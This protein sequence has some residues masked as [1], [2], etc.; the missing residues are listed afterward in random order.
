LFGALGVAQTA[1]KPEAADR[2]AFTYIGYNLQVTVDPAQ[3]S[4]SC[5]G[6]VTLRNDS[7]VAQPK[8]ALQL[9]SSLKWASVRTASGQRLPFLTNRI[10][11]DVDHTGAVNEAT[12][13]LPEAVR[14]GVTVIL[15]VGYSG[16][17]TLNTT[18]LDRAGM[19]AQV[20]RANDW[21]RISPDF[22]GVRGVGNVAW[23]PVTVE[24]ALLGE[25]KRM[26]EQLEAFKARSAEASVRIEFTVVPVPDTPT[27]TLIGNGK[28]TRG[29][30]SSTLE[31]ARLGLEAP[32]FLIGAY[33]SVDVPNG[34]VWHLPD[35]LAAAQRYATVLGS[36]KPFVS[37]GVMQPVELV[38]I[39]DGAAN[40]ESGPMFLLPL[41]D[42]SE[43]QIAQ[44]LI[45]TATHAAF[46]SPRPW[47]YEGLAHYSQAR[48]VEQQFGRT[49][50]LQFLEQRRAALALA[51]P[52]NPQGPGLVQAE[53]EILYRTKAMFVWWMLRDML[54][55]EVLHR[56]LA[57]Y[58]ADRDKEPSYIQRL[59]EA[60]SKRNL[61]SFFDDW[62]YRDRG[63]P[64]FHIVNVYPRQQLRG[65]YLTTVTVEN[66][67]N[68][69]AEVEVK[70]R[71]KDTGNT[72]RL[73]VPAKQ[74]ASIRLELPL[75]P[76][77]ATVNDGSVPET[78]VSNNTYEIPK[79]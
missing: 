7:K 14:P 5:R 17:I 55:E 15:D 43:N 1:K 11:S 59:L 70:I 48:M 41:T 78:D 35:K 49:G 3:H 30:S 66:S 71:A 31:F 34:R 47:I 72:G 76:T 29:T 36:V 46:Y 51:E 58:R 8:V 67:G 61:E 74:K 60:E 32:L 23:Y 9:S 19:S 21:D 68:A 57:K 44:L 26:L 28:F 62:V 37:T 16:T 69:G 24:P 65:G 2:S 52:E 73:Y 27:A 64:E 25:G 12:V 45:H 18:R 63:L 33:A 50:A 13:E 54:G 22:T 4:L 39:P 75:P 10:D 79:Q 77:E 6:R 40:Y 53:S 42:A 20:A 38:Q 56:A